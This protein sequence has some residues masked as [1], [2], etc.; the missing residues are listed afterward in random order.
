MRT[1]LRQFLSFGLVGVAN[2]AIGFSVIALAQVVF[3]LHAVAANMLGYAAGLTNSYL[4]NRVF[5][6]RG[7]T[8]STGVMLRFLLAFAVAYATNMAVLLTGLRVSPDAALLWQGLAMVSYTI[9]F[10]MI[11]KL[12]V[13]RSST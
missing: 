13:F 5:T 8:H 10:F 12:Y 7:A 11:S 4:M 6:F 1:G 2:T 3:G 9:V